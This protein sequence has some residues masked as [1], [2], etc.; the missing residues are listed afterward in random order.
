MGVRPLSK[1]VMELIPLS[2]LN[3]DGLQHHQD[4]A[5]TRAPSSAGVSRE[6]SVDI[7]HHSPQTGMVGSP[8]GSGYYASP[9]QRPKVKG[10]AMPKLTLEKQATPVRHKDSNKIFDEA[11]HFGLCDHYSMLLDKAK[12]VG[13]ENVKWPTGFTLFHLAAKKNNVQFIDWLKEND[14]RDIH[15]I[16]DFGKKP[17]DYA[18]PRK[19]DTVYPHL[20]ELMRDIP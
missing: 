4:T 2:K 16:D 8:F 19:K 20:E 6:G 3:L 13:F 1:V 18:C 5:P 9:I 15:A 14:C 10:E 11:H 12:E 7:S 17:I